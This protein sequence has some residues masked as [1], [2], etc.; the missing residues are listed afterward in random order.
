[1]KSAFELAMEK[2]G[3][4]PEKPLTNEQ[5]EQLAEVHRIYQAKIAQA[6][7]D[8][9]RRLQG[10]LESEKIKQIEEDFQVELC[11]LEERCEI[12]KNELRKQ[13]KK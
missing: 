4:T 13:F 1:M 12:K 8:F 9:A 10:V 11:S 6:K 3:G 5:K 2:L 7:F